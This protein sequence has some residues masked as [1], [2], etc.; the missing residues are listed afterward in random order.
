MLLVYY[1]YKRMPKCLFV[2]Y[3]IYN[4]RYGYINKY[5]RPFSFDAVE[6]NPSTKRSFIKL[7]FSRS[8]KVHIFILMRDIL[9]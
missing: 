7:S 6:G 1:T 2:Y 5:E 9:I 3:C 8:Y 4:K